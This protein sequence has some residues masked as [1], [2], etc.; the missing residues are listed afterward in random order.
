MNKYL[1]SLKNNIG[2]NKGGVGRQRRLSFFLWMR[3]CAIRS[4]KHLEFQSRRQRL[5]HHRH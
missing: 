5:Y 1:P 4:R 2:P 3:D